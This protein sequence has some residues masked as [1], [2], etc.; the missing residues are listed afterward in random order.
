MAFIYWIF[1]RKHDKQH[2]KDELERHVLIV[3]VAIIS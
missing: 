1:F 3:D 2:F